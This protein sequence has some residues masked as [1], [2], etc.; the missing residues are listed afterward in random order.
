MADSISVL[1]LG[2][3]KVAEVG[4]E[5]TAEISESVTELNVQLSSRQPS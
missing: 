4:T 1:Q 3:L 2:D 5:R